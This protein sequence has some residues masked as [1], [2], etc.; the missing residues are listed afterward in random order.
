M[1]YYKLEIVAKKRLHLPSS[2]WKLEM[3]DNQSRINVLGTGNDIFVNII[4][5]IDSG[6]TLQVFTDLIDKIEIYHI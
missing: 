4:M 6:C 2:P 1:I 5:G 3:G